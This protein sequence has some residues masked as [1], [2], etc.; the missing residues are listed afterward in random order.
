MP[1]RGPLRESVSALQMSMGWI[2]P[3]ALLPGTLFETPGYFRISLTASED[4]LQR[5]VPVVA[6]AIQHSGGTATQR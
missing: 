4:M 1:G 3:N 6:A 2:Y 5:A